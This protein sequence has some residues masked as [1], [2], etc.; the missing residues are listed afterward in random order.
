MAGVS[1]RL[2]A[3]GRALDA[4]LTGIEAGLATP[5]RALALG[6]ATALVVI[7]AGVIAFLLVL[8]VLVQVFT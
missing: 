8:V 7:V 4:W 2:D 5:G 3:V 6:V 1:A